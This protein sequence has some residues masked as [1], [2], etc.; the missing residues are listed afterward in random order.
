MTP[1]A[2][3]NAI[4]RMPNSFRMAAKEMI[5]G[6]LKAPNKEIIREETVQLQRALLHGQQSFGP[7][8]SSRD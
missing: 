1:D 7:N 4:Q 6:N 8:V 3:D 5:T 2:C